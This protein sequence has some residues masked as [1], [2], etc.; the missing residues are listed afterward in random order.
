MNSEHVET[1]PNPEYSFL[2]AVPGDPFDPIE[3]LLNASFYEPDFQALRIAMGVLKSHYLALGDAPWLFMVAPPGSGKTTV[4]ILGSAGLPGV[5]EL[6]NLTENTLVSGF[7]GHDAPGVLEKFGETLQFKIEKGQLVVN[8][9]PTKDTTLFRIINGNAIILIKDFTTILSMRRDKRAE[10][11]SQLRELHDGKY[12]FDRGTGVTKSWEGKLTV[13]AAVTPDV[14]RHYAVLSTLG[15]RFLKV[16]WSR[17]NYLAGRAAL[18]QQ[19]QEKSIRTGIQG[20][21]KELF[22]ASATVA[23]TLAPPLVQ[24]LIALADIV[25]YGR[26]HVT[27]EQN[28]ITYVPEPEANT[29][30]TK[31]LGTI[32]KGIA[33]L[34]GKSVVG[35]EEMA[36]IVRVALDS[37]PPG[38][39]RM[40]F[41]QDPTQ[42]TSDSP[43]STT[44]RTLQDCEA[45]RLLETD[46]K[47]NTCRTEF[48]IE[49]IKEAGLQLHTDY[50]SRPKLI[51]KGT[52]NQ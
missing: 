16:R 11:I 46:A 26:T 51:G 50:K 44:K 8:N 31:Q 41:A 4:G 47:G 48:L 14:D 36:D 42:V 19:G 39:R 18:D 15:E 25:A 2:N 9:G 35:D 1:I 29:R 6:G 32:G 12:E 23:P 13:L 10:I 49:R 22:E 45:L 3:T 28:Q 37:L 24:R 17:P 30:L 27:W 21:V 40:L 5:K 20:K 38:R 34:R 33:A 7:Y 43:A 52:K